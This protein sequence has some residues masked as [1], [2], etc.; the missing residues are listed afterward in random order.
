MP[1]CIKGSQHPPQPS[2]TCAAY[3]YALERK[4]RG[5]IFFFSSSFLH[6]Y[7]SNEIPE[8]YLLNPSLVLLFFSF[9]S[10]PL[11]AHDMREQV[12]PSRPC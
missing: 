7:Q 11:C 2:D 1:S 12:S 4:K 5:E 9:L 3:V 10:C 8:G 6:V